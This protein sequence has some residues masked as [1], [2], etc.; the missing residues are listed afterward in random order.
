MD[1]NKIA[2]FV[3]VVES[4]SFTKA[5]RI[6][7]QPKS[8]VSR[9]VAALEKELGTVL[10][11]RT[12]RQFSPTE[13]GYAL[14]HR[15]KDQVYQLEAAARSMEEHSGEVFGTLRLAATEDFGSALLGPLMAEVSAAHPKLRFDVL[16]SN[17]I[18]DLV[19]E[20]VDLAIR[21]G[22]LEDT[23]LKAKR[24]GSASFVLVASPE[25]LKRSSPVASLSDLSS[26]STLFFAPSPGDEN[27]WTFTKPG[28]GKRE[29]SVR[30]EPYCRT[31]NPKVLLEL[32]LAGKGIAFIPE[33]LCV[34][35]LNSGA[36]K[37]VLREYKSAPEPIHFVWPAQWESLPKVRAFIDIGAK[38]L[39]NYFI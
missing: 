36:L 31:S 28:G 9:R 37:R 39:G 4:G 30:V 16:L 25:Y 7:R 23:S 5:A 2:V 29:Y 27:M 1:L 17:E 10:V 13:A 34:D 24:I 33:Y 12:T 22:E 21:M 8:R 18:V 38:F 32:A 3:R 14:Y 35:S 20:R 11:Y 6:L 26:H 19:R 15:C